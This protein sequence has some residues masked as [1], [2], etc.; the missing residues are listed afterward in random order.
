ML[1]ACR[2]T[3]DVLYGIDRI[4]CSIEVHLANVA[5]LAAM[6]T[7]LD[8]VVVH[9]SSHGCTI[10]GQYCFWWGENVGPVPYADFVAAV[11]AP[12]CKANRQV[13]LILDTCFAGNAMRIR[14]MQGVTDKKPGRLYKTIGAWSTPPDY[15]VIEHPATVKLDN[16]A[17]IA[18]CDRKQ[19]AEAA[20]VGFDDPDIPGHSRGPVSSGGMSVWSYCWRT[21][22]ENCWGSRGMNPTEYR[23]LSRVFAF[24][25]NMAEKLNAS[26]GGACWLNYPPK[27]TVP[28]PLMRVGKKHD[29]MAF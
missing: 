23:K 20:W 22:L 21:Q 19:L 12:L 27:S 9:D 8:N 16:V 10:N 14:C 2:K 7:G 13:T 1:R 18:A 26:A 4:E 24:A 17:V 3:G 25:R 15:E 6:Y 28:T 29:G 11:I 5:K